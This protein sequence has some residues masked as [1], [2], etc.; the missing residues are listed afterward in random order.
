VLKKQ[1][2]TQFYSA[3]L[4]Y[5][6]NVSYLYMLLDILDNIEAKAGLLCYP[7]VLIHADNKI[8]LN[9]L[10]YYLD[11][12]T[13]NIPILS[14]QTWRTRRYKFSNRFGASAYFAALHQVRTMGVLKA[15]SKAEINAEHVI[16]GL[17]FPAHASRR[18]LSRRVLT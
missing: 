15:R 7:Y 4:T 2:L 12:M 1:Y 14:R 9:L 13:L 5:I 11:N 18:L 8:I 6:N 10:Y 3:E 16:Q 17:I